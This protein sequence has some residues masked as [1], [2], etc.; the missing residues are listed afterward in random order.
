MDHEVSGGADYTSPG[1]LYARV[2]VLEQVAEQYRAHAI[3]EGHVGVLTLLAA[4]RVRV[5]MMEAHEQ[6][7][8]KAIGHIYWFL[9]GAL[10]SILGGG[11]TFL[12]SRFL[13]IALKA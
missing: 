2:L 10:M 12:V 7:I 9:V 3:L 11:V 4:L 1:V 13:T 8:Q 5:E 6:D